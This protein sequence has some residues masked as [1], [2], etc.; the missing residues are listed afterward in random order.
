MESQRIIFPESIPILRRLEAWSEL[1]KII[2][3]VYSKRIDEWL[4]SSNFCWY[5]DKT[6]VIIQNLWG[7]IDLKYPG[8]CSNAV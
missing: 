3:M 8:N 2:K 6:I 1:L 7:F 4:L 5:I